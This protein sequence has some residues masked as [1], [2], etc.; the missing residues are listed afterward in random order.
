MSLKSRLLPLLGGNVLAQVLQIATIPLLTRLYG[1]ERYGEYGLFAAALLFSSMLATLRYELAIQLPKRDGIAN[2][3]AFLS[4]CLAAV[5]AGLVFVL[6]LFCIPY[7]NARV[8]AKAFALLLAASTLVLGLYNVLTALS[9]RAGHYRLNGLAKLVQVGAGAA[10]ALLFFYGGF[11]ALGLLYANILGYL[12][13]CGLLLARLRGPL[14]E[15]A[16]RARGVHAFRVLARRY[17]GFAIFNAPQ[18]IM[19]GLRPI[20]VVSFIQTTYG[21]AAAGYY[22]IANQ[23][24]QTPASVI[25][26]A[27][28]Q[29]HF[30]YLVESVGKPAIRGVMRKS[31]ILLLSMAA[32][33]A[34]LEQFFSRPLVDLLFGSKWIGLE[35]TLDAMIPLVAVNLVAAPLVYIFHATRRHRE[36]FVWGAFYNAAA[37][38]ALS[39]GCVFL[40]RANDSLLAY[41]CVGSV[42]L[43]LLSIR[44]IVLSLRSG[45]ADKQ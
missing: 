25:T 38:G 44:S 31:L 2:G 8:D 4:A 26:Q 10:G 30:R 17:S 42:V 43:G 40:S 16:R 9:L 19:D 33:G 15:S 12:A 45:K 22:H 13:G 36:F 3:L 6:A 28:S 35:M 23:L 18:A 5:V 1:P 39:I 29:V 21:G 37:I 11:E 7:L 14:V 20:A 24:L 34:L 32:L 41:S 27:F